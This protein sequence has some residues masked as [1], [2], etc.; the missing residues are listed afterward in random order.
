[1]M[2]KQIETITLSFQ[3]YQEAK[4]EKK[5]LPKYFI[6]DA[7]GQYVFVKTRDRAKAQAHID[8]EYGKGKY[9]V[10]TY[11]QDG[12]SREEASCIATETRRGQMKYRNAN[13]GLPSGV[14]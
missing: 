13:F 4:E 9:R 5:V 1:M 7:L 11:N 8:E 3:E 6:V 14:R 12:A 2:T 10:R